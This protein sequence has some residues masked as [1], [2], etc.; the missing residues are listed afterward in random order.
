[1]AQTKKRRKKK[2]RGTQ[3][4]SISKGRRGRP[5][6]REEAKAQARRQSVDRRL[7]P[8]TWQGAINRGAIGG[9]V[10]FALVALLF[11]RPVGEAAGLAAVMFVLY[12][13]M[14]YYLERFFYARR[15]QQEQRRRQAGKG[16]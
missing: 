10:F 8:P 12:I 11:G 9:V 15:R 13:P 16:G 2:H 14:G 4:G 1:M 6:T 7:V 3:G 5:R